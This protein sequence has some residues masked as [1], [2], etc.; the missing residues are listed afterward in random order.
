MRSQSGTRRSKLE[1][2]G[3]ESR[4]GRSGRQSTPVFAEDDVLASDTAIEG[5]VGEA[6]DDKVLPEAEGDGDLTYSISANLPC[7]PVV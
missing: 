6:I 5:V 3:R 7:W 4:S 1:R 2:Y